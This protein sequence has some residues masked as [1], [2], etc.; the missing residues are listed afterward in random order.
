MDANERA[1][2]QAIEDEM[3]VTWQEGNLIHDLPA[4]IKKKYFDKYPVRYQDFVEVWALENGQFVVFYS[5]TGAMHLF[6]KWQNA[7]R[8]RNSRVDHLKVSY[9]AFR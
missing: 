8:F 7:M 5:P 6:N 1:R 3:S 2:T 9:K 4:P